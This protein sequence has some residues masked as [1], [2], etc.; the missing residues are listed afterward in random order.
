MLLADRIALVTGGAGLNGLGFATARLLASQGATVVITDLAAARPAEA[1]AEIGPGHLGL[2]A[3]VT[4]KAE[5]EAAVARIL[6]KFGR[7]DI[8]VNNAGITQP[9]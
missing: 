2:V 7:I 8:L 6:E 5:V 3:N 4:V 1:A 9:R